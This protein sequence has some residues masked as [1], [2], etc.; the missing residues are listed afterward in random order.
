ML[1]NAGTVIV[2]LV[3]LAAVYM[4]SGCAILKVAPSDEE[5]LKNVLSTYVTSLEE[6][7]VDKHISVFSKDFVGASGETYEEVAQGLGQILPTLEDLGM[8]ISTDETEIAI[9]GN[10][11]EIGPIGFEFSQGSVEMTLFTTKEDDGCWRITGTEM[12]QQR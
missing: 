7:N 4:A 6:A 12:G 8:E 2:L 10:E 5:M 11:A 3:S 1:K 9:E